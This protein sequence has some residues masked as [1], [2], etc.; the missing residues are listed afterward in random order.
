MNMNEQDRRSHVDIG[1]RRRIFRQVAHGVAPAALFLA[2]ACSSG[3]EKNTAQSVDV[4]NPEPTVVPTAPIK[5][6]RCGNPAFSEQTAVLTATPPI[7]LPEICGGGEPEHFSLDAAIA[8][9][10]K[11]VMKPEFVPSEEDIAQG[12]LL[13]RPDLSSYSRE[14]TVGGTNF[15][16]TSNEVNGKS[17]GE[18]ILKDLPQMS[19]GSLTGVI[20]VLKEYFN[21]PESDK[22][23]T[24][25]GEDFTT[26]ELILNRT[27]DFQIS[28]IGMV[29]PDDINSTPNNPLK[30][31]RVAA[32]S[33]PAGSIEYDTGT[34][35]ILR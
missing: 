19:D 15:L 22:W 3:A 25:A 18:F 31:I 5:L 2:A 13:R 34:C 12:E 7:K 1:L 16:F 33:V 6:P 27:P 23:V 17:N 26:Y 20:N 21:V 35:L 30:V 28:L 11:Q 4:S 14:L 8:S 9:L 29:V 24:S 10:A 32:C